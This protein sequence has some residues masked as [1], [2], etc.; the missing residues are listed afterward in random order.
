MQRGDRHGIWNG[1][2]LMKNDNMALYFY[3]EI[4][5]IDK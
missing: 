2:I 3:E 4:N 5:K 1:F